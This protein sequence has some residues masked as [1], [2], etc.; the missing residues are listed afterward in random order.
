MDQ[1]VESD[2]ECESDEDSDE[3][4]GEDNRA[5]KKELLIYTFAELHEYIQDITRI[6][7]EVYDLGR[8]RGKRKEYASITSEY[9]GFVF[10]ALYQRG[11]FLSSPNFIMHCKMLTLLHKVSQ[12]FSG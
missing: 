8:M 4:N 10:V 7:E 2:V 1:K 9:N 6:L 12:K 3:D 5:V 11:K